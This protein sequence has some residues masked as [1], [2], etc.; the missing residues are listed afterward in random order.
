M[1]VAPERLFK[2]EHA[3]FFPNWFGRTLE[4]GAKRREPGEG[5]GRKD[6]YGG[7]GRDTCEA[8]RGRVS[9][10]SVF[11]SMWAL[12]QVRTF[13]GGA[14]NPGLREVIEGSGGVAQE[15]EINY[16]DNVLKYWLLRLFGMRK[17]RE[18]RTVEEQKRYF[19]VRR[20][21]SDIMK[22][23]LGLMN[24]QVGY[25]YL[26][27]PEMRV[28]WAG[29]AN[30]EPAERESL[31]RGVRKLVQ[32]AKGVDSKSRLNVAVEEVVEDQESKRAAAAA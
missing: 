9:V 21:V 2:A 10:V 13:V 14:Q 8:M 26:V 7:L 18:E 27:D 15:V 22:E 17:L 20:G 31:T 5:L 24:L 16:E 12:N 4:E 1:F 28:R 19:V 30:A 3:L 29:S 11:S 32:E 6:G 25:V 23:A